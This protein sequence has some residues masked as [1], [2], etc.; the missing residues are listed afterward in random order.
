LTAVALLSL[1]GRPRLGRVV[2]YDAERGLGLVAE[3][4]SPSG[5]SHRFHCTA[6][7]D[8]SRMIAGGASVG[9]VL[10]PGLGGELE[11]RYVTALA[12]VS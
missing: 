4:G 12:G 5:C 2:S 10:A 9:F 3:D 8:G 6:I 11:A 1:S 7:A